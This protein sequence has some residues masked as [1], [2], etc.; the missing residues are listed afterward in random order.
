VTLGLH[1]A[2]HGLDGE[3]ASQFAFDDA[4]HAALL[5]RDEMWRGFSVS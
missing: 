1:V 5:T 2:D 4:E 3:S